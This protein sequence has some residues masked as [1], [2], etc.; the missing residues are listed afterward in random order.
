M[1][2]DLGQMTVHI[3]V[4]WVVE[5]DVSAIGRQAKALFNR[6]LE[7]F[8]PTSPIGNIERDEFRQVL[9]LHRPLE[10]M[11]VL[12]A[13][14][15]AMPMQVHENAHSLVEHVDVLT[16][17]GLHSPLGGGLEEIDGRRRRG[18]LA[19]V[20]IPKSVDQTTVLTADIRHRLGNRTLRIRSRPR[21]FA[22]VNSRRRPS[23]CDKNSGQ[24]LHGSD[25]A[26]PLGKMETRWSAHMRVGVRPRIRGWM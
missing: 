22:T 8:I 1:V 24:S 6:A 15:H 19:H 4:V 20:R 26:K 2:F 16:T 12:K 25:C 11:E 3:F 9:R 18:G 13:L 7:H 23:A 21:G 17:T 5:E 14:I 10:I